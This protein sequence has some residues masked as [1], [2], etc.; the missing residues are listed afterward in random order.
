MKPSRLLVAITTS[1]VVASIGTGL[2]LRSGAAASASAQAPS[3]VCGSPD[4]SAAD[5]GI[6]VGDPKIFDNRTLALML[7]TL[8][9]SLRTAQIVDPK[10]LA[11]NL[12]LLQGFQQDTVA[13]SFSIQSAPLPAVTDNTKTTQQA[14]TSSDDTTTATTATSPAN[15]TT[16]STL[17]IGATMSTG[18][19]SSTQ[20]TT[21]A[22]SPSNPE[23]AASLAAPAFTP[24]FGQN[25][26]DLLTDQVN[27][28]YQIFNVRML[29][30]R[31]LSDRLIEGNARLQAVL[32][33]NVSIDPPRDSQDAAAF[34]EVS[35]LGGR[36]QPVSLVAVM[37][38]EKTYNSAT[39]SNRSTAFG[40]SAVAQV[41]SVGYNERRQSQLFYLFR[42]NDTIAFQ[43]M[44]GTPAETRFGWA[45]RPVLG[46][47]SV[48]PGLRQMFAVIAL[49]NADLGA[50]E[51]PLH[52]GVRT[53][54]RH[55]DR[56]TM[57]SS[58][59]RTFWQDAGRILSLASAQDRPSSTTATLV[60]CVPVPTTIRFQTDLLPTIDALR[61]RR[62]DDNMAV[63]SVNGRNFFQGTTV[64][65]GNVV[66]STSSDGLTLKSDKAFDLVVPISA[67]LGD[68]VIAGRYGNAVDLRRP[69]AS[70]LGMR[71]LNAISRPPVGGR[72]AVTITLASR[73][74]GT[75][76][77][78][79]DLPTPVVVSLGG[80]AIP[81]P[82]EVA[83]DG[84]NVTIRTYPAVDQFPTNEGLLTV[85]F[86]FAGDQ[87]QST[88]PI[89]DPDLAF[90]VTRFAPENNT[91][92]LLVLTT[93][94]AANP[95]VSP[96]PP[97]AARPQWTATLGA[98]YSV[99]PVP[100]AAA[101]GGAGVRSPQFLEIRA[102][103][104]E[105]EKHPLL[106][107]NCSGTVFRLPMPAAPTAK[108]E[109]T[110]FASVTP[111]TV[112][113]NDA[114]KVTIGGTLL[115]RVTKVTANGS[116][117]ASR[118]TEGG[119]KLEVFLERT[120]TKEAGVVTLVCR[121]EK[122]TIL[123]SIDVTIQ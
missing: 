38:Q 79:A 43:R 118:A 75:P 19:E 89:Y 86:P 96:C 25:A 104:D 45:F 11:A 14:G 33:F 93:D 1:F 54:W 67:L 28:T 66:A 53:F 24:Q 92:K 122:G 34:V 119:K 72:R 59:S 77:A 115:D 65:F 39:L 87:W 29:L 30:E 102:V 10:S 8:N 91:T 98:T 111:S 22:R 78:I 62:T 58:A 99:L 108:P 12:N 109:P 2:E 16:G 56:N 64:R 15:N 117:L 112:K 97:G 13:R 103:T 113:K 85:R 68:A 3:V 90:T 61:W 9:D 55:F 114:G 32:G 94:T 57:T 123:G 84:M 80:K 71:I 107:T 36:S 37:P 100:P 20:T 27:L 21:A 105:I 23:L 17:K 95:F 35:I 26:G 18:Q 110:T 121:D 31:A 101:G 83:Q 74:S 41:F 46:R 4:R 48:S 7:D 40:G 76:L 73:T 5:N 120:L 51:I 42:D 106:L 60:A 47:R 44:G 63:V 49:P 116:T 6:G 88:F 50:A 69:D 82:Y 70:P 81:L 52:I